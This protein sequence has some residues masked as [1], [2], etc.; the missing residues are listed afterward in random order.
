MIRLFIIVAFSFVLAREYERINYLSPEDT[1]Q[2]LIIRFDSVENEN[3]HRRMTAE[4]N[5]NF[6]SNPRQTAVVRLVSNEITSSKDQLYHVQHPPVNFVSE[7]FTPHQ[8]FVIGNQ[9]MWR[10]RDYVRTFFNST[11]DTQINDTVSVNN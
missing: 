1:Y 5:H 10:R 2:D 7:I 3:L 9:I 4:P 11:G 8:E 6:Q